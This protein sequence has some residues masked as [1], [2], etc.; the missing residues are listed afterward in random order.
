MIRFKRDL[1]RGAPT[2]RSILIK[3]RRDPRPRSV[4]AHAPRKGHARPQGEGGHSKAKKN[5]PT[6]TQP[7]RH[8]DH[9][10]PVPRTVRKEIS[11]F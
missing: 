3:S 4:H 9:E 5:D 8:P 1:E 7:Y 10:L 2:M 11:L 6:I